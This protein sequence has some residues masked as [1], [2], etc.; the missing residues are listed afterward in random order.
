MKIG[1]L[2]GS[3]NPVHY[4]HLLLAEAAREQLRLD[5]VLLIPA[6]IPPHKRGEELAPARHRLAM[7]RAAI[8]GCRGLD[9][10]AR[11]IR[12]GGVSFT[13]DTLRELSAGRPGGRLYLIVGADT[14]AELTTWREP[15]AIFRLAVVAAAERPGA[16]GMTE[17]RCAA[18]TRRGGAVVRVRM[19]LAAISASDL[20]E[21]IRRGSSIRFR[22]PAAVEAYIRRHRLYR[23]VR[24]S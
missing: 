17:A 6:S 15:D 10:D 3:F 11:E 23:R 22:V 14:L 5:R 1:I 19:P 21:R 2:G 13:V 24:G 8:R 7:L 16:P 9:A 20:R 12:R 18:V 4:G